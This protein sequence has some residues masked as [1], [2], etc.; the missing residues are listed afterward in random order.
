MP[1][2]YLGL[3]T[4]QGLFLKRRHEV[5]TAYG[6]MIAAEVI[7]ARNIFESALTG[8]M[9]DRLM[10]LVGRH[11]Q[12]L[13]E[14][15]AG[16]AQPLLVLAVGGRR[17]QQIKADMSARLIARLPD[18]LRHAI[19]VVGREVSVCPVR[20]RSAPVRPL[21][22]RSERLH[23][24]RSRGTCIESASGAGVVQW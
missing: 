4:W 19:E 17:L 12:K 11:V 5:A 10:N 23:I 16:V 2:R 9:S 20:R 13:I 24:C 14:Q 6:E 15:Q 21:L 18:L 1:T 8:R 3:F 7:T 22:Y